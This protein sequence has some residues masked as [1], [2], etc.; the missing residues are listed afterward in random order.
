MSMCDADVI[1]LRGDYDLYNKPALEDALAPAYRNPNV[2]ID[3]TNVRFLDSSALSVLVRKRNRRSTFGFP[4][5]RFAGV[6]ENVQRILLI[7]GL[8]NVWPQY[9]TVE[10]AL[11]LTQLD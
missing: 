3:F 6:S 8:G 11:A 10:E 9:K 2:V 7:S 5:A 1:T 4:P